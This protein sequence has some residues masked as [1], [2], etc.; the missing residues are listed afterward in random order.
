MTSDSIPTFCADHSRNF[1]CHARKAKQWPVL[2]GR[3]LHCGLS[4]GHYALQGLGTI[5]LQ[6]GMRQR[7]ARKHLVTHGGV[8]DKSGFDESGLGQ[9]FSL[10]AFVGIHVG[11]MGARAV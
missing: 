8:V 4:A 2:D 9:I 3:S 10:E 1:L 5:L 11:M 6:F 7:L